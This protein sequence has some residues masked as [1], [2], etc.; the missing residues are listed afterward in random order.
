MNINDYDEIELQ[1]E[2]FHLTIPKEFIEKFQIDKVEQLIEKKYNPEDIYNA[3]IVINRT[4]LEEMFKKELQENSGEIET[5]IYFYDSVNKNTILQY[6][7]LTECINSNYIYDINLY[8]DKKR[9]GT[10]SPVWSYTEFENEYQRIGI[11]NDKII[12]RIKKV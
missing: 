12:I 10:Y 8:K 9:I 7:T 4:Q 11:T 1:F 6:K 2:E 3:Y 5:N